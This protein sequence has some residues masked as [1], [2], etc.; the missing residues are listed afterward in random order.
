MNVV[1][2]SVWKPGPPSVMTQMIGNELKTLIMLMI[3]ATSRAGRS[4]GS[5]MWRYVR[6]PVAPSTLAAS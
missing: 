5:V 6:R 3:A 4:S 1:V 2:V